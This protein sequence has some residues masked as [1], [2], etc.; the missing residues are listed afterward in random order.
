MKRNV[1]AAG[2][3]LGGLVALAS[4]AQAFADLPSHSWRRIYDP[5]ENASELVESVQDESVRKDILV[6]LYSLGVIR[7]IDPILPEVLEI[8]EERKNFWEAAYLAKKLG[9]EVRAGS[10][11]SNW[12]DLRFREIEANGS[13]DNSQEFVSLG[14]VIRNFGLEKQSKN[15]YN[16]A[17][18]IMKENGNFERAGDL[19]MREFDDVQRARGLYDRSLDNALRTIGKDDDARLHGKMG[20]FDVAD[21]IYAQ[22]I[23]ISERKCNFYQVARLYEER[24]QLAEKRGDEELAD[25]FIEKTRAF[26][27]LDR[28][29]LR[30]GV[31]GSGE[32]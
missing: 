20:H 23:N 7:D 11:F 9:D 22:M 32:D 31:D 10:L 19:V 5:I 8:L 30:C 2:W 28:Y 15:A 18:E 13:N 26:M 6:Q 3:I 29:G 17:V 25:S 12:V 21:G 1:G 27:K 24:A 4:G 16:R 14:D